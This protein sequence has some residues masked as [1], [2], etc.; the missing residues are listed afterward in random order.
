MEN[1]TLHCAGMETKQQFHAA[2]AQALRFPDWYGYNLDALYDCL[3][4]MDTPVHLH[5][6]DWDTLPQ[7]KDAFKE[8]FDAALA[9]GYAEFTV[10]YQ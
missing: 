10:T 3:T 8:V 9:T 7:W 4:D 5:L 1:I 2:I 6:T